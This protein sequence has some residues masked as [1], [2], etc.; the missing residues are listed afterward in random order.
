MLVGM[1]VAGILLLSL[2]FRVARR[3]DRECRELLAVD[4]F[5]LTS[6]SLAP[7]RAQDE[8]AEAALT[9]ARQRFR[10]EF[11]NRID[12][13]IVFR[14]LSREDLSSIVEI[15]L[16]RLRKLL[17]DRHI[18]LELGE[19]AREAVADAGYDPVYGARPL[20]RLIQQELETPLARLLVR[21]ELRDGETASVDRKDNSLAIVPT[22]TAEG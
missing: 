19:K 17:A 7:L 5:E 14:P 6:F 11:L 20:K 9:V 8:A 13:Q 16:A 15:Q 10:P 21:G 2:L 4:G 3:L 18:T 22:V 12:E 1:L